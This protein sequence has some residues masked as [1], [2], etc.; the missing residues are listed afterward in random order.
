MTDRDNKGQFTRGVTPW[1][2]GVATGISPSNKK[3]PVRL[4]CKQC[5]SNFFVRPYRKDTA[6]FC[7]R[8][9]AAGWQMTGDK[10]HQWRGGKPKCLDCDRVLTSYKAVYCNQHKF[11]NKV[12]EKMSQTATKNPTRYWLGKER[13][14]MRGEK[15]WLWNGGS[16]RAYK[17]GYNSVEYKRWRKSVFERDNYICQDCGQCGGYLTAHHIRSFAHYPKL[18]FEVDNGKTLCEPCHAKTDN[19]KARARWGVQ[20]LAIIALVYFFPESVP[21]FFFIGAT[22]DFTALV[23]AGGGGGGGGALDDNGAGGGGAGGYQASAALTLTEGTGYTI[24]VGGGGAGN[25]GSSNGT[26]GSNSSIGAA[27]VATGG[28]GGGGIY[29]AGSNGGSGGGGGGYAAAGGNGTVG[30]GNDGGDSSDDAGSGGGGAGAVGANAGASQGAN[31]GAGTASSITGSS[32]TRAGGGGGGDSAYGSG[33]GGTGGTG[34]GGNGGANAGNGTDG[35]ANTGGG[36]GGG[37]YNGDGG[38]GGS[39]VVIIR[40]TTADI[41]VD[42]ST[43]GSSNTD[44]ADTYITWNTSGSFQFSLA[45]APSVTLH[46]LSLTGA[47]T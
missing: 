32:V 1:N 21:A 27:L 20:A 11:T 24:T 4:L 46:T 19:Y 9:C 8:G 12:R 17:T 33:G 3:E 41:T 43:N 22:Y 18:R 23:I 34:G 26:N 16:S 38:N 6:R 40:F 47:G 29:G 36:G 39:G 37:G 30:Q 13:L 35:T 28:G 25:A 7:S 42:D 2:K 14:N 15:N 45:G 10:H 44:G 31:G 5:D